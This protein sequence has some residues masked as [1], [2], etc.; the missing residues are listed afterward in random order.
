M[1]QDVE[2]ITRMITD[3]SAILPADDNLNPRIW[4]IVIDSAGFYTVGN[5]RIVE[6]TI[7]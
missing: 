2:I 3:D 1:S 7:G 5:P 4:V 6:G